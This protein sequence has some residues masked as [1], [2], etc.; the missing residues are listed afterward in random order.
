MERF[1]YDVSILQ[2]M[3]AREIYGKKLAEEGEKD[4]RIVVLTADLMRANK[5][6]D[7]KNKYP[8][9]FYN[10]GIAE[11]DMMGIAAGMA[12]EG[13]MPFAST[14]STFASMRA[15]EQ[16]RMDIC[17]PNLPVRIVATH[18]GLTSGMGP[19]H[20]S[21][22][23]IAITRSFINMTV[24]V[25]GD[26][27]QIGKVVEASLSYP[28]PI[29]IRIGRG[30]EPVVYEDDYEY[31]IGKAIEVKTGKDAAIIA[32]GV[33]VSYALE[34]A[35]K[36]SEKGKDVRVIDMH[37]I[38]PLDRQAV[39]DAARTGTIVT[40]EDHNITGGLG[41]AVAEVLAEENISCRFKRLGIPNVFA[42][43]GTPEELYAKYGYDGD[44]I[45]ATLQGLL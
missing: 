9:R 18:S 39:I 43:V 7:F 4:S 37:T 10:T 5:T 1:T 30:M 8:S 16:V 21:Q 31:V 34:A 11:Q 23:D 19:T 27:N 25:P 2:Q 12:L 22:E 33:T 13:L 36:M 15:C 38:K 42:A 6:G 3:T 29:Y 35:S 32:C 17:Y 44:G 20:Y 28:G 41:T 14:F 24:I 26:P 45:F 40:V